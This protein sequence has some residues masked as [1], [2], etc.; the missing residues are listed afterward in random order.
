MTRSGA[1]AKEAFGSRADAGAE[2]WDRPEEALAARGEAGNDS[3][4]EN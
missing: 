2:R 1:P 3:D 4:N